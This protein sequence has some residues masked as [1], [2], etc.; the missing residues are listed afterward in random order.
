M[1]IPP[2][3]PETLQAELT[4]LRG[5][6]D[7][8]GAYVFTKDLAGRYTYANRYVLELFGRSLAD[9]IGHDDSDFFDLNFSDQ[10]RQN[11]RLVM[12]QGLTIEKEELNYI[13]STGEQRIYW[14]VKKPLRDHTGQII[15]MCGIST[16]ITERKRLERELQRQQQLLETVLNNID[17]FIYIRD[18]QHRFHYV[19]D[20]LVQ[21]FGRPVSEILGRTE[22][23]LLPP[24]TS[25]NFAEL[26]QQVF[27]SGQRQSGQETLTDSQGR[28]SH[29]WTIKVPLDRQG[30]T[31][32]LIGFSTEI[33]EL[34]NLQEEL[35]RLSTT[36]VLT[37]LPNRR[38][39]L[40][41]AER[42]FSR[43]GRHN[44]PLALLMLDID[45]FKHINDRY[46]HPA[47]DRVLAE[48]AE[49]IRQTIRKEDV[50]ARLGGEEFAVL[51]PET[52]VGRALA[53]AERIRQAV[54]QTPLPLTDADAITVTISIGLTTLTSA[55]E[56][57]AKLYS[58]ADHFLYQ[59][60]QAGRNQVCYA[61]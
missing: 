8:I 28:T 5:L 23:E 30:A 48:V 49:R 58:R 18:E 59:A 26:D 42:E 60:K 13:K 40:D 7:D 44:V 43:A 50:A 22:A 31:P 33:T 54:S 52:E 21:L 11:D 46:G 61:R 39:F 9:T 41:C 37:N 2:P 6:L 15:G 1:S 55:D 38:H 4:R 20:K 53:L 3:D 34:H 56:S 32:T 17:A 14:T 47:G 10:L 27:R 51:L 35:Q 36:D 45:H 29:Y 19:N 24:G 57:F 16:D 12:E 25:S